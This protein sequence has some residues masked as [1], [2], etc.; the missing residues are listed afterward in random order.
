MGREGG[1]FCGAVRYDVEGEPLRVTHCHCLHCRRTS[2]AAFLTWA[3]FRVEQ[4]RVTRGAPAQIASRP[5]VSRTFC[6]S[7]GT[8]LTYQSAETPASVDVTACSLDSPDDLQ[9][10]DHLW[11]SRRLPWIRLGDGLPSYPT[12]RSGK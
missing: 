11:V 2:G 5:G 9:P 10:Q 4:Y 12:S 6:S 8:A 1:C 7:C 3:E